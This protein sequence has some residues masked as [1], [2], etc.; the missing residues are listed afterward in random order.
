MSKFDLRVY[1]VPVQVLPAGPSR[2][3]AVL[4]STRFPMMNGLECEPR[5]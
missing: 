1:L 3:A 2:G 5:L 4:L